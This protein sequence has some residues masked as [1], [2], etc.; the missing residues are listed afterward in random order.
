MLISVS[1]KKLSKIFFFTWFSVLQLDC[2]YVFD[3][4]SKCV[5]SANCWLPKY[6]DRCLLFLCQQFG[7]GSCNPTLT[8]M[9][10]NCLSVVRNH[11][12]FHFKIRLIFHSPLAKLCFYYFIGNLWLPTCFHWFSFQIMA[13]ILKVI[14][15]HIKVW[16]FMTYPIVCAPLSNIRRT[17]KC[18][19]Y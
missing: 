18:E 14:R 12:R 4:R 13:S 15:I 7:V 1:S 2:T 9:L 10:V 8:P 19:A 17:S 6:T 5:L 11:S 16:Y 3:K